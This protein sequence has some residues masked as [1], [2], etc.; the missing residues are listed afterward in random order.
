MTSL[1]ELFGAIATE[2][3]GFI[4]TAGVTAGRAALAAYLRKRADAARDILF[5]ELRNGGIPPE[6][7]A[8][9]DDGI[10]VIHGFMRA[11]WEGKARVNLRL[12]AKAITGQL[13]KGGLVADEFFLYA[14]SLAGLSRDEII[15]IAT[16]YRHNK[17]QPKIHESDMGEEEKIAPWSNT[18]A[19]VET[20]GWEKDKA[21]GVAGRCLRSGLLIAV[22]AWDRIAYK[23]SP[24]LIDLCKTVDFEDALRREP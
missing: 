5:D 6:K 7:V 15:L 9:E 8:T 16:V 17:R 18:L 21:S 4:K 13:Q 12:L 2:G 22:S 24:M 14:E 23:V 1:P 19:E 11:A 3:V 20:F 10:A